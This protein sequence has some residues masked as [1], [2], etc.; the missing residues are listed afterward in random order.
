MPGNPATGNGGQT[1]VS[2]PVSLKQIIAESKLRQGISELI[3]GYFQLSRNYFRLFS[4]GMAGAAEPVD[5]EVQ[6][7]TDTDFCP[8]PEKV[9]RGTDPCFASSTRRCNRGQTPVSV[10]CPPQAD[11]RQSAGQAGRE[12]IKAEV[13][14]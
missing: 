3:S 1:P 14:S 8:V 7:G 13:K 2:D 4:G 11:L 10:L 12:K 6:P 9:Q 5:G